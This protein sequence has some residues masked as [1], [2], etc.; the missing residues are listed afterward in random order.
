LNKRNDIWYYGIYGGLRKQDPWGKYFNNK[1]EFRYFNM[2]RGDG[3]T[4]SKSLKIDQKNELKNYWSFGS[5]LNM[6]FAAY[7]NE[8]TFRDERAWVYQSE[9]EG[10]GVLWFQTDRR[11]KIIFR[12]FIGYGGGEYRARGY[13]GGVNL[14]WRPLDNMNV[15]IEG[16]QDL[17]P[18]SME[19][20]GIDE[21]ST[22]TSIIYAESAA[23]MKV[24][25]N[26]T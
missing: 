17:G 25:L 19:W 4:L 14:R 10:Y 23:L 12:P 22:G 3:L 1:L 26:L 15:M 6:Q 18:K 9:T 13:R 16:F 8:D 5:E 7:N 21:D 11:K 24:Q 20:V 2:G